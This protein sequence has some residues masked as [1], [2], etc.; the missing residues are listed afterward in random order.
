MSENGNDLKAQMAAGLVSAKLRERAIE[1]KCIART[2][3][4]DLMQ[5]CRNN[6]RPDSLYC[7]AHNH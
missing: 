7:T 6:A 4:S 5:L 3:S 1:G 2:A